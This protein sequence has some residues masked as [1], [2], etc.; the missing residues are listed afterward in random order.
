MGYTFKQW[1]AVLRKAGFDIIEGKKHIKAIKPDPGKSRVFRVQIK[2]QGSQEVGKQL[3][4]KMLNQ[5]GLT[6][7]EFR[8]L[9]K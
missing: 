3:H 2:R 9:L 4:R 6:E 1:E 7:K 8:N 5:S